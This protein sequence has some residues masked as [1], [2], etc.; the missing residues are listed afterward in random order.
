VEIEPVNVQQQQAQAVCGKL[1]STDN[2]IQFRDDIV[3]VPCAGDCDA[4]GAGHHSLD[5]TSKLT[6]EEAV[7]HAMQH[8][9][10]H[11]IKS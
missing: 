3:V 9:S 7:Q 5:D 4:A 2:V 8:T 10:V 1:F 11:I 6:L